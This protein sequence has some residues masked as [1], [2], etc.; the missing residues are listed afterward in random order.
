MTAWC[1][2]KNKNGLG[3]IPGLTSWFLCLHS[4]GLL[5]WPLVVFVLPFLHVQS[6]TVE[7]RGR[8]AAEYD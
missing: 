1:C 3:V 6:R 8:N 7:A 5:P 4:V 2:G